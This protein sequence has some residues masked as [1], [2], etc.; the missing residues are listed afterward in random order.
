MESASRMLEK[1]LRLAVGKGT[2]K[3]TELAREL[4]VTPALVRKMLEELTQRGYLEAVVP[5]CSM[6]C[7]RCPLH[8]A[9][10]YRNQPRIWVLTQKG[11]MYL[12]LRQ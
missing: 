9:C 4:D 2:A 8:A 7:E 10:A 11:D 1:I 3:T 5:G 12:S 6:P